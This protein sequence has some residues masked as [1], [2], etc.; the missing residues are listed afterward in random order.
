MLRRDM[1]AEQRDERG[2]AA[3]KVSVGRD[4]EGAILRRQ[5]RE[6]NF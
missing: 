5:E 6:D 3:R 1:F 2:H 4:Y